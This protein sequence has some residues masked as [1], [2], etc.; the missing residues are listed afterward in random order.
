MHAVEQPERL[1]SLLR[2]RLRT[3]APRGLDPTGSPSALRRIVD[4]PIL[5][6]PEDLEKR[7]MSTRLTLEH[8]RTMPFLS[9]LER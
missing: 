6:L 2:L 9:N 8:R 4:A 5:R 1:R 3:A 7:I